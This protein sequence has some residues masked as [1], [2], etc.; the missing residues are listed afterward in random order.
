LAVPVELFFIFFEIGRQVLPFAPLGELGVPGTVPV[1]EAVGT[2]IGIFRVAGET[3]V[4]DRQGLLLPDH[5]RA[6]LAGRLQ[7]ALADENLG[8]P[9]QFHVEPVEPFFENIERCVWGMD[10]DAL[11]SGEIAHPEVGASFGD[12]DLDALVPFLGKDREFHLGVVGEAEVVAA[13]EVDL[14]L[15]GFGPHLVALDKGEIHFALF[16]AQVGRP[17]DKDRAVDV[18]QAGITVGV[19]SFVLGHEA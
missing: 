16:I 15:A 1:V 6:V 12:M 7:A 2:G 11:V 3:A 8:F 4:R 10:F 14:G 5:D 9:V 18:A 13:A 19:E 17:L